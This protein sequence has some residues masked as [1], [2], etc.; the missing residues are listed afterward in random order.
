MPDETDQQVVDADA[1][2]VDDDVER[3]PDPEAVARRRLALA[4]I[5]QY[6]DPV[7]RLKARDVEDFDDDLRRLVDRMTELMHDAGGA[8]L[9]ATQVGILRRLFVFRPVDADAP[10]AVVNA[11]I[12]SKSDETEVDDEGCLSLQTVLVPVERHEKVTIE[13]KDPS[14]ADLRLELEGFDARVCQHELDHLDGVLMLDRTTDE[15]RRSALAALR[16]QPVLGARA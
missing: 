8:G 16:G 6:P 14:G 13:G 10:I 1:E 7:L 2:D 11:R 15:A 3:E 12:T 4:Q 5:R 9:A